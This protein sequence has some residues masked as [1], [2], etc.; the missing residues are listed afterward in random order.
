M[1]LYKTIHISPDVSVLL[2]KIT[3]SEAELRHGIE[4]TKHCQER[5]DGMRSQLHR[6]GFMSI[7][8]LMALEG[9]EDKDLYYDELGKP[10]LFD[11]TNIS[12]TH[13]FEFTGIIISK[14]IDVGIDI[15][16]QREKILRIAH[17]FTTYA[18]EQ[19]KNSTSLV[20][21]LTVLWGAKES[22]YKIAAIPGLSFRQHIYIEPDFARKE[23]FQGQILFDENKSDY[24]ISHL[25]FEGFSC[26][27]AL[28]K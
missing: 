2:W 24:R 28:G 23:W 20:R 21:D 12:I 15:E 18:D 14:T 9:Y 25:D 13:S 6:R 3:E 16:M 26:V 27:F 4:L 7:R 22:L 8:H 1:P 5:V 17:K 11:G 19:G 10:H